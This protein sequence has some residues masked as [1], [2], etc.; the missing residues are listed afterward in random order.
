MHAEP[1]WTRLPAAAEAAEIGQ[2]G[3]LV[4]LARTAAGL[5]LEGAGRLVGYSASTLSRLESG[6]RPL[7]DVR[8]LRR[9]AGA[10]DI[11]PRMF[12]LAEAGVVAIPI[13]GSADRVPAHSGDP[14]RE[15]GDSPV[16]RRDMLGVLGGGL[17]GIAGLAGLPLLSADPAPG[18]VGNPA[19]DLISLL[20]RVLL[21][22]NGPVPAVG[23]AALRAGLAGVRADFQASR[24][25][26]LAH[27]LPGLLAAV[28]GGPADPAVAAELYNTAAHVCIKLKAT[29]LG[30]LAADR[31]LF[32]ARDAVD[33]GVTANITRNVA[34][35]LR[36]AGRYD[37]AQHLALGAADRLS[38]SGS[39]VSAEHL[40]LYGML[41]CNAGYAAAQAGDRPRSTELLDAAQAAAER[42]GGDRNEHWTAFGPTE[43]LLHRISA[44]W[45]LGDAGTAID[46]ARQVHSGA[47]RLPERQARYWIDVA[48]AFDQ[49]GKPAESFRA[50]RIAETV[51]PEELCVQPKVRALALRLLATPTTPAMSG[52]RQF[53]VRVGA[54]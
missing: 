7:T 29:G 33:A 4:R 10:L 22:G 43:V 32:A 54:R 12:G 2:Y 11:P 13:T 51:A 24:Y 20:E 3:A 35:L 38:V 19:R 39:S 49:W 44:A 31:A 40:S 6:K 1:N 27:R 14:V 23:P 47:I 9:L 30:W 53:A 15:G 45:R 50:L 16:R 5:T 46:H 21:Y 52:L 37:T 17:V 41:L 28:E 36:G 25:Q 18:A 48:R 42:L 26:A 34:T 8:V